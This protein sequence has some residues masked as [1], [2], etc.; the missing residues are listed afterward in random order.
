MGGKHVYMV[1]ALN[2]VVQEMVAEALADVRTPMVDKVVFHAAPKG[3]D[4]LSDGGGKNHTRRQTRSNWRNMAWVHG[5][6]RMRSRRRP[7]NKPA[8][9]R[10][11]NSSERPRNRASPV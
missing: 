4:H 10:R 1:H 6:E 5:R 3:Y 9:T 8:P 11:L 7:E 2:E